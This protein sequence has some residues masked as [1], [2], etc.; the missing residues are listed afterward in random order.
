MPTSI[1]VHFVSRAV[2]VSG[3]LILASGVPSVQAGKVSFSTGV[4]LWPAVIVT[5][6]AAAAP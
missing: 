2:P 4:A 6:V 1:T 5:G 3:S